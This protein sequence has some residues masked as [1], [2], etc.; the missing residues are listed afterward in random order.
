[1]IEVHL[2]ARKH[3]VDEDFYVYIGG[4]ALTYLEA[5]LKHRRVMEARPNAPKP[6]PES[7]FVGNTYNSLKS[8]AVEFYWLAQLRDLG[9]Y[10]KRATRTN[11]TNRNIHQIR[12]VY[13]TRVGRAV[14]SEAESKIVEYFMGHKPDPLNYN[15][16]HTQRDM[17][18]RTYLKA[19]RYLDTQQTDPSKIEDTF[20][21]KIDD[22]SHENESL[23]AELE[24]MKSGSSSEM[25]AMQKRLDD[26]QRTIDLM[27]PTFNMAQRMFSQRSELEKKRGEAPPKE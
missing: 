15:Q 7:I 25:E 11:R 16:I 22:L 20:T 18:I 3:N 13:R 2:G 9:L 14:S 24:R 10:E 23:T 19:L 17:R 21:K 12:S 5:W 8:N 1:M 6:F 27:M 4:S 26:Q